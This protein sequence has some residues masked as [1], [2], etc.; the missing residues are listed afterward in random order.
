MKSFK[1]QFAVTLLAVLAVGA[2][3]VGCNKS[4]TDKAMDNTK[5]AAN[6]AKDDIKDAANKTGDAIKN[7]AAATKDAVTNAVDSITN[8]NK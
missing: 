6:A 8:T 2:V 5:D 1:K 3:S 7:G 4:D